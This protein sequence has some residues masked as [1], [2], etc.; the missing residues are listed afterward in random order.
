MPIIK[1]AKKKVRQDKK[2]RQRRKKQ[3]LAYRN[4]V[5]RISKGK[6]PKT[7]DLLSKA[8]SQIDKAAKKKIIHKK[9]A[10]RLK[11]KL[12]KLL[13]SRKPASK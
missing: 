10:S 6:S 4:L 1:S 7:K 13:R 8:F 2:K 12:S 11:S 5:G 3:A 9:K